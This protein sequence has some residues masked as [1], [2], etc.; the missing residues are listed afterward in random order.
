MSVVCPGYYFFPILA[1]YNTGTLFGRFFRSHIYMTVWTFFLSSELPAITWC[2]IYRH[3]AAVDMGSRRTRKRPFKKSIFVL[4]QSFPFLSSFS[5]YMSEITPEQAVSYMQKNYPQCVYW[6]DSPLFTVYD[7]NSNAWIA[8]CGVGSLI[9]LCIYIILGGILGVHTMMILQKL[10]KNM[11]V[12]TYR[13]HRN[14]LVSLS[15]QVVIPSVFLICPLYV[16]LWVVLFNLI[17]YQ[18]FASN[19]TVMIGCHS[20]CSSIVM[21][22]TNPRYRAL[23]RDYFFCACKFGSLL[24][25]PEKKKKNCAG[26]Q[27]EFAIFWNKPVSL[28]GFW[29]GITCSHTL[30]LLLIQ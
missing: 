15:L 24:D 11:S 3:N 1:G 28:H 8:V 25:C 13:M 7:Y 26:E 2:F 10:Q 18:S 5:L 6:L 21:I 20:V 19:M 17:E 4:V 30:F 16:C 29:H 22:S 27:L 12:K 9:V 14:A 23:I